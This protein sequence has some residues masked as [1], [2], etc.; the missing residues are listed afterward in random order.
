MT[1]DFLFK[2]LNVIDA[3]TWILGPSAA[4][5]LAEYGAEVIKLE[6]P[7]RMDQLR[8]YHYFFKKLPESELDYPWQLNNHNK[9]GLAL[10][11]KTEKG[12]AVFKRLIRQSDV[13]ISNTP[14]KVRRKLKQTYEE[15]KAINPRLIYA[16][17]SAFGEEGPDAELPGFD[18]TAYWAPSGLMEYIHPPETR[19]GSRN[20]PGQ[21]DHPSAISL[22][23]GIVTAL[24]HREKTGCGSEVNTS[25]LANG[26]W[27]NANILQ[28]RLANADFQPF[29]KYVANRTSIRDVDYVTKD[30]RTLFLTMVRSI[31]DVHQLGKALGMEDKINAARLPDYHAFQAI[32]EQL[33]PEMTA[34]FK[35]KT[36]AEWQPILKKYGVLAA[37]AANIE[38]VVA[39]PQLKANDMLVPIDDEEI[40]PQCPY[41]IR[42]PVT[43][44]GLE[45]VAFKRAPV[46]GEHNDEILQKLGYTPADITEL[47]KRNII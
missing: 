41:M 47:K 20:L 29:Y 15:L 38:E 42:H 34:R 46:K 9:K 23:A 37:L 11:V 26:V 5:I 45:R 24:L 39:N 13:F 44:K 10:N 22:Y 7:D 16:S 25:L 33:V 35:S 40:E 31:E 32:D 18:L 30:G 6:A 2:D 3:G 12:Y 28:G 14:L 19:K 43:V 27:T 8:E 4:M 1:D 17:V 21:G 36:W